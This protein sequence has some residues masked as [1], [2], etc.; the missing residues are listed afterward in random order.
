MLPEVRSYGLSVHAV[1]Q[2]T[3]S[4]PNIKFSTGGRWKKKSNRFVVSGTTRVTIDYFLL[5]I[6]RAPITPGTHPHRVSTI[7]I[8]MD[9]Q[10]LS[11]TAKGGKMI[12]R[13]TRKMPIGS[14]MHKPL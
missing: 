11:M 2:K 14:L 10:P 12:H 6:T 8:R 5:Q 7:T 1:R 4:R 3:A 13:S 9:P